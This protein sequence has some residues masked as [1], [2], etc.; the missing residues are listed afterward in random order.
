MAKNGDE[1][2]LRR[3]ITIGKDKGYIT[4]QELND[5]LSNDVISSEEIDDL[6]QMFEELNI[7]VVSGPTGG[8]VGKAKKP[9]QVEQESK[10]EKNSLSELEDDFA[11]KTYD[12][13]KMY[14]REMG[15]ISLLS[16][17]G[18][19]EIAKRIETGENL[20]LDTLI[21]CRIGL[22]YM[23]DLGKYLE[24]GTLKVRDIVN[25]IEDEFNVHQIGRRR[26]LLLN[27]INRMEALDE[28]RCSLQENLK[29]YHDPVSDH[30]VI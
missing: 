15:L 8:K 16:R 17:E 13:V 5:D 6:L 29:V 9:Q 14:L 28:E 2:N 19:V 10:E 3:L 11:T 25:D 18:E 23:T 27:L 7:K 22:E 21:R 26:D 30:E 4:Y 20:V 24:A 12:P 1:I